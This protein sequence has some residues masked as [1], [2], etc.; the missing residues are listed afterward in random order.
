MPRDIRRG[1]KIY[2]VGQVFIGDA[3]LTDDEINALEQQDA[4]DLAFE[5]EEQEAEIQF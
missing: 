3:D 1:N 4:E 5:Q 2:R